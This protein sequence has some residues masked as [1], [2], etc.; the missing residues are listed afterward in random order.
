MEDK[1]KTKY[2]KKLIRGSASFSDL[3]KESL[4]SKIPEL[5]DGEIAAAITIF[6]DEIADWKRVKELHEVN[7]GLVKEEMKK[8]QAELKNMADDIVKK[9]EGTQHQTEMNEAEHLIQTI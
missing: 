1:N 9:A 4:I 6:E 8:S 7:K 2:L 5:S 3:Q